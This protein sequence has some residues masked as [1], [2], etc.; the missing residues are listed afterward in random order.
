M[1]SNAAIRK[2]WKCPKCGR[3]FEREGQS[4]SCKP[5]ALELHF[6]G[7]PDEKKLYEQLK[8]AIKKQVGS[9]KVESLECCIHLVRT[10]TFGAVKIMKG[11]IRIDFALSRKIKSNRIASEIKMSAYRW[12]Y[13]VDVYQE[14]EIDEELLEWIKEAYEKKSEKETV[15]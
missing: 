13:V 14:D 3:Q 12:L 5:Y 7:K 15:A 2:L 11:K 1:K 10:F 6:E 9:F 8:L 4:H